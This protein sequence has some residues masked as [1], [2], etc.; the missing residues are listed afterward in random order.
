M[1]KTKNM[2][3]QTEFH[4]LEKRQFMKAGENSTQLSLN[5]ELHQFRLFLELELLNQDIFCSIN[6]SR[7][8]RLMYQI[9]HGHCITISLNQ[10]VFSSITSDTMTQFLRDLIARECQ[11]IQRKLKMNKYFFFRQVATIHQVV[12]QPKT[13]GNKYSKQ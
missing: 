7:R 10:P 12:T 8:L 9:Q 6:S 11:K 2:L 5:K 4:H 13:S 1:K 3:F